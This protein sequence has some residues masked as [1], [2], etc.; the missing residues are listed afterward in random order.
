MGVVQILSSLPPARLAGAMTG[1]RGDLQDDLLVERLEWLQ[2]WL[3]ATTA[4]DPDTQACCLQSFLWL[5]IFQN[6]H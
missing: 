4:G 1:G 6:V 3:V 5:E 2:G